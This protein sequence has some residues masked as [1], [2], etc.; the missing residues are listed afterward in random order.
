MPPRKVK[1]II[2]EYIVS[3]DTPT[4][5]K[6]KIVSQETYGFWIPSHG[7]WFWPC[8]EDQ[9]WLHEQL[10]KPPTKLD[11]STIELKRKMQDQEDQFETLEERP[12]TKE[13]QEKL[14]WY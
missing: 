13:E 3:G 10:Q 9:D 4:Y 5:M 8:V 7:I 12:A 6:N 1:E 14:E 11:G 2:S